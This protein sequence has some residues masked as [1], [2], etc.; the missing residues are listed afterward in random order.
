MRAAMLASVAALGSEAGN[1]GN[2]GG[3]C[4]SDSSEAGSSVSL[5]IGSVGGK[6]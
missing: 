1:D 4:D 3:M 5:F 6:I 2:T